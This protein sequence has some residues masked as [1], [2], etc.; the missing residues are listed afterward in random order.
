[1]EQHFLLIK[2]DVEKIHTQ[3]N[4]IFIINRTF[5]VKK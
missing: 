5:K 3:S 2:N 4:L 1:M